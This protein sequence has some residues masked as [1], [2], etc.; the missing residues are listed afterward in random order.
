MGNYTSSLIVED[1]SKVVT[2]WEDVRL[3]GK[4]GTTGIYKIYA[5]QTYSTVPALRA[6]R[7]MVQNHSY[8]SLAL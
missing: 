6:H 5:G 7:V 1:T 3:M 4:V 2:V 8:G